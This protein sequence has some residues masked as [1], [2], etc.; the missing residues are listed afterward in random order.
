[1]VSRNLLQELVKVCDYNLCIM[2]IG[3]ARG[4]VWIRIRVSLTIAV[5]REKG[6]EW[7]AHMIAVL[8]QLANG[9]E[10]ALSRKHETV[11]EDQEGILQ[12]TVRPIR[13]A[14]EKGRDV[15]RCPG[16]RGQGNRLMFHGRLDKTKICWLLVA[17]GRAEPQS[18]MG[19]FLFFMLFE[20][21]FVELCLV[22]V[23]GGPWISRLTL[24]WERGGSPAVATA[25]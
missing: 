11:E 10:P 21:K 25:E 9:L 5:V 23:V 16:F 19:G 17:T 22:V 12:R 13:W 2:A 24:E 4:I 8:D 20:N 15:Q 14:R 3:S 6:G 7:P 1:M 18:A